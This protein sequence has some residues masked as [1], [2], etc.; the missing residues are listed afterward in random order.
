MVQAYLK[1]FNIG[2]EQRTHYL[3]YYFI[4]KM[5]TQF[6]VTRPD[7]AQIGPYPEST[8]RTLLQSGYLHSD[9]IVCA[10]DGT[11]C[12]LGEL[13]NGAKHLWKEPAQYYVTKHDGVQI[14]PYPESTLRTLLK[15]GYLRSDNKVCTKEAGS[16]CSLGEL[17]GVYQTPIEECS[18]YYVTRPDGA[19]IGPYEKST[20]QTLLQS[21]Y[22]HANNNVRSENGTI[23]TLWELLDVSHPHEGAE[24]ED[25]NLIH[26]CRNEAPSFDIHAGPIREH[27]ISAVGA[28]A[29]AGSAGVFLIGS[30]MI[31]L[32]A[33]WG[34]MINNIAKERG[35]KFDGKGFIKYAAGGLV[36]AAA[37]KG[38]CMAL[39]LFL[40]FTGVG[41]IG[42]VIANCIVNGIFT[43]RIGTAMDAIFTEEGV[44]KSF[45][46]IAL[47]IATAL[48]PLPGPSEIK[49]IYGM[50]KG[51]L[52]E[53]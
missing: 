38:G 9:G 46:V 19:E 50:I 7:G 40:L 51:H 44:E 4:K 26:Q 6:Y 49:M 48:M 22:L 2:N 1:R 12:R 13:L 52:T 20:L 31:A 10:E 16:S 47:K 45:K 53:S 14:G 37:W 8:L 27:I 25:I 43:W 18:Q 23:C 28:S 21:G 29:V 3:F 24:K 41:A 5:S 36:A 42:A 32:Y 33:I 30:D 39:S 34:N 35:I 17:L 11:V 15:S